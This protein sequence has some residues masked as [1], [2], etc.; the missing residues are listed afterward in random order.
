VLYR[1]PF[2]ITWNKLYTHVIGLTDS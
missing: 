2:L 1:I